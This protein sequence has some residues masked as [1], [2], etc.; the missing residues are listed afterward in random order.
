M[1]MFNSDGLDFIG[2]FHR[3]DLVQ[4]H[5]NIPYF[6]LKIYFLIYKNQIL[7]EKGYFLGFFLQFFQVTLKVFRFYKF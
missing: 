1:E 3:K 6:N 4:I 2:W 7:S 5:Q